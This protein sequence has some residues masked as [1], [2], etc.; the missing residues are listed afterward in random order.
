[1][2]FTIRLENGKYEIVMT[3]DCHV[4]ATRHGENWRDFTGDK[5]MCLLVEHVRT[6]ESDLEILRHRFKFGD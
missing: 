1:M 6:L 4:Y 2:P 3:D 5:M